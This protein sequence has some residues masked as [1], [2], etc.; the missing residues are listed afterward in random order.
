MPSYPP[1]LLPPLLQPI[2]CRPRVSVLLWRRDLAG[3]NIISR[4]HYSFDVAF[5]SSSAP[6]TLAS[7]FFG[8]FTH[9][10]RTTPLVSPSV[11]WLTRTGHPRPFPYPHTIDTRLLLGL[12]S[13]LAFIPHRRRSRSPLASTTSR[14]RVPPTPSFPCISYPHSTLGFVALN[15]CHYI[16]LFA[17]SRISTASH[18]VPFPPPPIC[19]TRVAAPRSR[20]RLGVVQTEDI[21]EQEEKEEY[22][23]CSKTS[24]IWSAGGPISRIYTSPPPGSH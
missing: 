23:D 15:L 18:F 5:A 10:L 20:G 2:R 14:V 11:Y 7:D 21:D 16:G 24:T 17:C 19:S 9:R 1:P 3:R 22:Q 6:A 13:A 12:P 4:Y 8:L